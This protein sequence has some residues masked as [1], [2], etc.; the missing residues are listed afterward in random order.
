VGALFM[1]I[2]GSLGL[3]GAAAAGP[4]GALHLIAE[5]PRNAL[6]AV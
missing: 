5:I 6:R 4:C 2:L 1:W 3:L